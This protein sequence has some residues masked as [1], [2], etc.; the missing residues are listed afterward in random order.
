MLWMLVLQ[1]NYER[2]AHLFNHN[3][4]LFNEKIDGYTIND[5]DTKDI[6]KNIYLN[7]EY[8]VCLIIQLSGMGLLKNIRKN[9][10]NS[11]IMVLST[12]HPGKFTE[13]IEEVIS[14]KPQLPEE[15]RKLENR[16]KE[17]IIVDNSN[18]ALKDYLLTTY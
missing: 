7:E 18:E 13:V 11:K 8:I 3:V 12:A 15:L 6:I 2:M 5:E 10:K 14:V 9:N 4:D 1:S 16:E 17:S